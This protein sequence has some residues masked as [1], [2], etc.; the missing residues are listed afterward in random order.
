MF[1][2]VYLISLLKVQVYD[3]A[4]ERFNIGFLFNLSAK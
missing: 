3:L 2:K 1:I 4:N